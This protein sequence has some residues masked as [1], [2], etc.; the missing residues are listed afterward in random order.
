MRSGRLVLAVLVTQFA[1]SSSHAS[2]ASEQHQLRITLRPE[3]AAAVMEPSRREVVVPVAG[4]EALVVLTQDAEG[5][6]RRLS[7]VQLDGGADDLVGGDEACRPADAC[8]R[9]AVPHRLTLE[10]GVLVECPGVASRCIVHASPDGGFDITPAD[11]T[12]GNFADHFVSRRRAKEPPSPALRRALDRFHAAHPVPLPEGA[13]VGVHVP[14]SPVDVGL[15]A[16]PGHEPR[17][18]VL[19]SKT[20]ALDAR[21]SATLTRMLAAGISRPIEPMLAASQDAAV[22]TVFEDPGICPADGP[23]VTFELVWRDGD[24]R[25]VSVRQAEQARRLAATVGEDVDG[26]A[27]DEA[28]KTLE[29]ALNL[30]FEDGDRD[31]YALIFLRLARLHLRRG[32]PRAAEQ[33]ARNGL[34]SRPDSGGL[35]LVLA[36]ALRD[37]GKPELALAHFEK[38]LARALG[39]NERALAERETKRLSL[40]MRTRRHA[41]D[42][43]L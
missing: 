40:L 25:Q 30:A 42:G 3:V 18:V 13:F 12:L 37:G 39:P 15:L 26:G 20:G 34:G 17:L 27:I 7:I 10:R 29:A 4:A 31:T 21:R 23:P 5:V 41:A 32:D 6:G 9:V 8:P 36:E 22:L 11:A 38:A 28:L 33:N 24:L 19:N 43:G 2:P 14:R 35:E 16:V 1:S